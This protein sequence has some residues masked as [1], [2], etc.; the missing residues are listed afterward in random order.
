MYVGIHQ[1]NETINIIVSDSAQNKKYRGDNSFHKVYKVIKHLLNEEDLFCISYSVEEFA[2]VLTV[3]ESALKKSEAFRSSHFN[4]N[5]NKK[6]Y[7]KATLKQ[8]LG[9]AFSTFQIKLAWIRGQVFAA[10]VSE[11]VSFKR[12]P[13]RETDS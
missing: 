2:T 7:S 9:H 5:L 4:K 13:E 11:I 12:I 8:T 6:I 1:T 10:R 3:L